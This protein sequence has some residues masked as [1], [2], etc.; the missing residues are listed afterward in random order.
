MLLDLR[1]LEN[2]NDFS[3]SE[4]AVI[5]KEQESQGAKSLSWYVLYLKSHLRLSDFSRAAAEEYGLKWR[6]VY[7]NVARGR[8]IAE[9]RGLSIEVLLCD[10]KYNGVKI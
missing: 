3:T 1:K 4:I 2:C 8:Q 10:P 6:T 5:E 7:Q 9:R